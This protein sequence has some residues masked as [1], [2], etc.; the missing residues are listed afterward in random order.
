M[1]N[2]MRKITVKDNVYFYKV[3]SGHCYDDRALSILEI[4][5]EGCRHTP[6]VMNFHCR[7][8]FYGGVPLSEGILLFNTQTH[9]AE[10]VNLCR[11]YF[12]RLCILKALE[13]EWDASAKRMNDFGMQF[14]AELN[15]DIAP[16]MPKVLQSK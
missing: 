12:V 3:I 11:P 5:L 4:Y 14:L 9:L 16:I 10:L 8:D 6:Y 15:L 7:G 2:K 13:E 1:K